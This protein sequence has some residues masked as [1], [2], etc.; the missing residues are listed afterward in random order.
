YY[1]FSVKGYME[2]YHNFA[3]NARAIQEQMEEK[4]FGRILEKYQDSIK[5]FSNDA[6]KM[7]DNIADLRKSA[8]LPFLATDRNVLNLPGVGKSLTF[9]VIGITRYGRRILE[10]DHDATRVHSPIIRKM[11]K[12]VIIESK[13]ISEYLKHLEDIGENISE[14]ESIWGYSLGETEKRSSIYE[15]PQYDFKVTSKMTNLDVG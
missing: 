14:Y 5:E 4:A 13:S 11:G 10:F 2:N 12:M 3:T 15:Y 9:R 6:E 1:C 8:D 7:V